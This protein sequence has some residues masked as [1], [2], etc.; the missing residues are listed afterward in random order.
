MP[1]LFIIKISI[2][3][4]LQISMKIIWLVSGK[5]LHEA[6]YLLKPV[7]SSGWLLTSRPIFKGDV[8]HW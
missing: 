7:L 2:T 4:F 5:V 1:H 3:L 8:V 6:W